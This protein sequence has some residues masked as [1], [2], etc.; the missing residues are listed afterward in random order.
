[1]NGPF[2]STSLFQPGQTAIPITWNY[3]VPAP[4]SYASGLNNEGAVVGF[5]STYH[6][7]DFPYVPFLRDPSGV[8]SEIVCP[9]IAHTT[10]LPLAINDNGVI[11]GDNGTRPGSGGGFIATP[12]PGLSQ[13]SATASNPVFPPQQGGQT[14]AGQTVT[15]TNTGNARLDIGSME[16]FGYPGYAPSYFNVSGCIDPASGFA[17][18]APGAS[19]TLTVSVTLRGIFGIPPPGQYTDRLII[20]DN[21]PGSPHVIPVSVIEIG[22]QPPT[23]TVSG[24][25]TTG[26]LRQISFTFQ[27]AVSGLLNIA[28]ASATNATTSI[29][30]VTPGVTTP[31]I[32]SMTEIDPSQ[33]STVDLVATNLTG[34]TTDCVG[35]I[36]GGA[37]IWTGL[38]GSIQG[39][40]AVFADAAGGLH[41]FARGADQALLHTSQN[42]ADLTWSAWESFGGVVISD[43]A[44]ALNGDGTLKSSPL[45]EIVLSGTA[46]KPL[47]AGPTGR[48]SV[49]LSSAIQP[50][51]RT[52]TACSNCLCAAAISPSGTM[53]QPRD[54]AGF[55]STASFWEIPSSPPIR[56]ADWKCSPAAEMKRSGRPRNHRP[57]AL[58]GRHGPRS[59]AEL[60]SAIPPW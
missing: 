27:D 15:I 19:C 25:I 43:P 21:S 31:V 12:R 38:S 39:K 22:A 51:R 37:S 23:C 41:A 6:G 16:F 33:L 57:T 44:A 30:T 7:G 59:K 17:S 9:G 8:F 1:M 28:V 45:V 4:N 40:V 53:F 47:R 56:T 50:L 5:E 36:A 54:R 32:A 13:Y 3:P 42:P 20:D 29:P 2:Y 24:L 34:L 18:L 60:L 48:L 49:A 11:A 10:I 14:S 46:G 58:R 35:T 52:G 26:P 55:L